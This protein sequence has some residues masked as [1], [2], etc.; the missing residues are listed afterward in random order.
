MTVGMK[1]LD[2]SGR[3]VIS[4][5][6][7]TVRLVTTVFIPPGRWDRPV[8][9]SAPGAKSG[10]FAA[11]GHFYQSP[12]TWR[13]ST[14]MKKL[15]ESYLKSVSEPNVKIDEIRDSIPVIPSITVHDGFV[16]LNKVLNAGYFDGNCVVYVFTTI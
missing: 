14:G 1:I 7:F 16:R 5:D 9:F 15:G 8:D 12:T 6:S 11:Y 10:M 2:S 13:Y 3:T 4:T